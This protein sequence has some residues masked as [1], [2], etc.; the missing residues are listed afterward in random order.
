MAKKTTKEIKTGAWASQ[1]PIVG[2]C[3]GCGTCIPCCPEGAI[4][5]VEKNG[6]KVIEINYDY[7]KGCGI[8]S[9]VCPFKAIKMGKKER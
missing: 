4:K 1:K 3:N 2:D 7:C 9:E 8:C 6:K 5:M